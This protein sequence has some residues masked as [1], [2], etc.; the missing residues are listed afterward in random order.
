MKTLLLITCCL[1]SINIMLS[2]NL[3]EGFEDSTAPATRWTMQYANLSYPSGNE[4]IHSTDDAYQGSQSFRFSSYSLGAP[5]DQYLITP[6]L[7]VTANDSIV[8]WYR[9]DVQGTETFRIGYSL[10]GK[11]P[12]TDFSYGPD[13]TNADSVWQRLVYHVPPGTNYINIHY[14]STYSFYLY[15]DSVVGPPVKA[16]TTAVGV[17]TL[18][19]CAGDSVNVLGN[20]YT[21]DTVIN[22]TIPYGSSVLCDTVTQHVVQL[23]P[24]NFGLDTI[25]YCVGDS[26]LYNGNWYN[27]SQ[28]FFDT[29]LINNSYGCDSLIQVHVIKNTMPIGL[30]DLELCEGDSVQIGVNWYY[31]SQTV[32]DTILGAA[33]NGCDSITIHYIRLKTVTPRLNIGQDITVC[34][35]SALSI[36]A[37][38]GYDSYLWSNGQN[39]NVLSINGTQTGLGSFDYILTVNQASTGC[40]ASDTVNVQFNS[41]A[42]I[43]SLNDLN[44]GLVVY[45]NPSRGEVTIN[46]KVSNTQN[47]YY[48]IVDAIG[49]EIE[50]FNINNLTTSS[51]YTLNQMYS[52]GV[53][54]VSL[55][56]NNKKITQKLIVF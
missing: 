30:Q 44:Y 56:T 16:C 11:N 12:L 5:Y 51:H 7:D 41:C 2:Q 35:G 23:A 43:S 18:Y 55:Y 20:W 49:H 52:K 19:Y 38:S 26:V 42:G 37:N 33:S 31:S 10:A 28:Q 14:K 29:L 25:Y 32:Y 15:V 53:Y 47:S 39:T 50:R 9:K 45:P 24:N 17:D 13:I 40:S 36:F 3:I 1:S 22:D 4:M 21:S 27:S 8:F 34:Q 46:T 48:T 54:F 6:L